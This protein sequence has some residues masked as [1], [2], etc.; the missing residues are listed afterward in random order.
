[1]TLISTTGDSSKPTVEVDNHPDACPICHRF[2]SI[3]GIY[4]IHINWGVVQGLYQCANLDCH[5]LFLSTFERRA[6]DPSYFLSRSEP[7]TPYDVRVRKQIEEISPEFAET[8][9]QAHRAKQSNLDKVAGA[10]FRRALEF[11][12]KDYASR[13]ADEETKEKIRRKPLVQS[14]KDHVPEDGIRTVAERAA[15]LGNDETHYLRKWEEKD[16]NDLIALI[17]SV[18]NWIVM[19]LTTEELKRTMLPR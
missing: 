8:Y 5:Q 12:V 1:M 17:D 19:H 9:K 3:S 10:G 13:E 6:G 2:M 16:V 4:F 18:V 14:I 15:W 11:L 7:F